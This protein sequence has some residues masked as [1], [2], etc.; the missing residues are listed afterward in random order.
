MQCVSNETRIVVY[1]RDT[2]SSLSH[3]RL[4]VVCVTV[5]L[6]FCFAISSDFDL[7]RGSRFESVF[8]AF[9]DFT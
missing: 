2:L 9:A 5:K 4:E 7:Q 1:W 6:A 3:K 8:A